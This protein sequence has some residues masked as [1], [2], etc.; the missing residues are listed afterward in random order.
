MKYLLTFFLFVFSNLL[1][2]YIKPELEICTSDRFG[3]ETCVLENKAIIDHELGTNLDGYDRT[4]DPTNCAHGTKK[5]DELGSDKIVSNDYI[6][7][8][9]YTGCYEEDVVY[10]HRNYLEIFNATTNDKVFSIDAEDIQILHHP[11][12]P[13][14]QI[15][16]YSSS[17]SNEVL[18]LF[19]FDTNQPFR[20]IAEIYKP[21]RKNSREIA[22]FYESNGKILIENLKV[23]DDKVYC[24]ACREYEVETLMLDNGELKTI[25]IRDFNENYKP[26]EISEPKVIR[27][28]SEKNQICDT[29]APPAIIA[30]DYTDGSGRI[31]AGQKCHINCDGT[32]ECEEVREIKR[33]QN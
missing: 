2:A 27:E 28:A 32:E 4:K 22:G 10:H 12:V 3:I 21:I 15:Q 29:D 24:N 16:T 8:I 23:K 18:Q 25:N 6:V 33:N 9:R 30:I 1:L 11:I 19:I 31:T 26:Y 17:I 20:K 13:Y 7:K 14:L 5:W